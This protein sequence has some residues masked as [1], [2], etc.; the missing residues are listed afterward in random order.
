[1]AHPSPALVV[2]VAVVFAADQTLYDLLQSHLGFQ[3]VFDETDHVLTTLLL[4]WALGRVFDERHLLAVLLA[5]CLI[6][7]DH[8]PQHLG[9]HFLTDGTPRPYTHSLT[10]VAGVLLL[11]LAWRHRRGTLLAVALGLCSHF[12]RDLAEPA[13][14][15]VSIFWPLTDRGYHLNSVFY[16]SSIAVFATCALIRAISRKS[17]NKAA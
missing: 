17:V 9:Y 11:A 1:L 15:S 10:T 12:W 13:H 3:G 7:V 6:D 14:A 5:S 4:V 16:L 2:A 8:I